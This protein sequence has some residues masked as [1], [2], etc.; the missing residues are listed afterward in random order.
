[1]NS[2]NC[3]PAKVNLAETV[4]VQGTLGIFSKA[5]A[6]AGLTSI[7]NGSGPLTVF[8]PCDAAFEKLAAGQLDEWLKPEHKAELITLLK[9]H[10]V[11]GRT[12]S[13]DM[14]NLRETRSVTGRAT[15]IG[16]TEGKISVGNARITTPDVQASNGVIHVIDAVI[17]HATRH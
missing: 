10:V 8:A 11:P 14:A 13:A 2:S 12:T 7:L 17:A 5:I 6:A 16:Q 1:M 3:G 9:N 15:P 4:A